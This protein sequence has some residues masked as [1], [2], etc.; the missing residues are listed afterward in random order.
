MVCSV[1][2]GQ[3]VEKIGQDSEYE[4][5]HCFPRLL[6]QPQKPPRLTY[7][8]SYL[9]PSDG[10]PHILYGHGSG[11]V[12]ALPA[13]PTHADLRVSRPPPPAPPSPQRVRKLQ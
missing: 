13:A 12:I 8:C 5:S 6:L 9:L 2:L 3:V 4:I 1:S 11:D 7:R 10:P